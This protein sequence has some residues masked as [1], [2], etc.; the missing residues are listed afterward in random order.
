MRKSP[1][2]DLSRVLGALVLLLVWAAPAVAASSNASVRGVVNDPAG[3][4]VAGAEVSLVGPAT[5]FARAATTNAS[6]AYTFGDVP[7][8]KYDLTVTAQG[9]NS[10]VVSG[11]ELNVADVRE[12]NVALVA[13][14]LKEE[15][16]VQ[17]PAIVVE[18]IGGEVTGL[19]TGEQVRELP[20]NGRNFT[21]LALLMPG[22]SAPENFDT[23]NK[24]LMTGSDL[25]ISGGGVTSNLWTI[26]G[27]NNNDVG[28]NRTILVYPS[29]DA[30]EEFKIH[31]NSYGPE[32][33]GA[34]GGQINLITRAG[35]N[36]YKGS[37]FFFRRDDAWNQNNYF[38]EQSGQDK[39][40]L[41][42]D[43]YGFTFG[44]PVVHDKLFAFVSG[45]WNDETRGV[46]RS[47][48]VPTDAERQGDF[49]APRIPGCGGPIP[50]VPETGQPFPGNR[51][52]ADRLSPGG[53]LYLQLYP[54]ANVTPSGGSC[55][56]WVQSVDTPIDWEQRNARLDWSATDSIQ[57][58]MRYT[59]D[60]WVNGA[61]NATSQN[62]LWGDDPFP[63]V[64]SSWTQP[65]KSIVAQLSQ[66]IG[67]GAV[68]TV[69]FSLS[70]NEIVIERGGNNAGLN[71]QIT[72]A[73]PSFFPDSGRLIP[74][75]QGPH[76]TFWGGQGYETLW[77]IAPWKNKQDLK[78]FKDDYQGVFGDHWLKG[79]ILYSD[80]KKDE[81]FAASA[82]PVTNFWGAVNI[83][84]WGSP[85][86][87]VLADFL[88]RDSLW[89]FGENAKNVDVN[90]Q[91]ND[92]E[93]YVGDSWQARRGLTV[94][95]GLRY[96]YFKNPVEEQDEYASF[97]PDRFDPAF[98]SSPCNGLMLTPGNNTCTNL[99]FA[100][101][102]F[103]PNRSLV[104]EDKN[105]LAPRLGVAWD[106][107]GNGKSALRAGFGQFYQRERLSPWLLFAQNLFNSNISGLRYLDSLQEPYEGAFVRATA[108]RPQNGYDID[109][110]TPYNNQWN[111]TWE[112]RLGTETTVELSYVGSHG[113]HLMRRVDINQVPAGDTNHNGITDR[114]E[115]VRCGTGNDGCQGALRPY[116]IVT[117]DN[118]INFWKNDGRSDYK[119]IQTQLTSRFGRGSQFQVSYTWSDLE[120]NDALTDSAG[121]IQPVAITD[122]SNP[123]LDW[124]KAG[125]HR[126]HVLNSSLVWHAP[127]FENK[128]RALSALLGGWSLGGV[129]SYATGVPLTIYT[130]TIPGIDGGLAGTG[131]AA[132][133]R[134]IRVAGQ[135]CRAHGG[136]KEQ[137]LNPR[138]YTL[139]GY[140]L[141]STNQ[142]ASRGDCEGP[143]FFQVDL[144]FYKNVRFANRIN[145]QLRFEV[146]NVT[147]RDNFIFVDTTMD[148]ISVTFD[149]SV[150][151]AT[152]VVGEEIPLNFG[153]ATATRD[154][155]QVQV[156]IKLFFD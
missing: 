61:P 142:M 112:Q 134:P 94:D 101:G 16:T 14:E 43:D 156:G 28:S 3:A 83:N 119:S 98:G 72:A 42:R 25:S 59:H 120:A 62:G 145:G 99:G 114:L 63:A 116:G 90:Q 24:G 140:Q 137:W 33:G 4:A 138:A 148:P 49:S 146:F 73:I 153:Q 10:S 129:V 65:G 151:Q 125:I 51:I 108:G 60:E 31:R 17:A 58:M 78:V 95:L 135:S 32:F 56:N 45:E 141:G 102:S 149:G 64:D 8:G 143:D 127:D 55:F 85:T 44:G 100:G 104:K 130:G 46:V 68:N 74:A 144:M 136:R 66:T 155:R 131:Y 111:L 52:P 19:V 77:N 75:G 113:V 34:S 110:E 27:A 29:V 13:G 12:I 118:T 96:S 37:V 124:G 84:T 152:R 76:P 18:T 6:G 53:L 88:L 48:L 69:N 91:W 93:A 105:N 117:G 5:G 87:N 123:G 70:G 1:V 35:D 36:Q 9:F 150:D 71:S 7:P 80:N 128:G 106:V 50:I 79:G 115:Y 20:L 26:D 11:L 41:E 107:F 89:G 147:N 21:Q 139:V 133:Q 30:I 57:V 38:L 81:L 122:L 15:I 82:E 47:S 39:A 109:R 40:K 54:H 92:Y 67:G 132:N 154:P 126:K 121:S 86:G 23:K 97:N 2:L 103:G 22:V